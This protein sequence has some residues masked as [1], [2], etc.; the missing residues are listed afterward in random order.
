M[1]FWV[2]KHFVQLKSEPSRRGF[3]CCLA[4]GR[5]SIADLTP[6][7]QLLRSPVCHV[8]CPAGGT[9]QGGGQSLSL[10]SGAVTHQTAGSGRALELGGEELAR[11]I[12]PGLWGGRRRGGQEAKQGVQPH[13]PFL[14][15][16]HSLPALEAPGAAGHK[17]GPSGKAA[18][19]FLSVHLGA[20]PPSPP[21]SFLSQATST[22]GRSFQQFPAAGSRTALGSAQYQLVLTDFSP[23]G[24]LAA[25]VLPQGLTPVQSQ[26]R[27][28][29]P[30]LK[31]QR[32]PLS[33]GH[34]P[35]LCPGTGFNTAAPSS[36]PGQ[37][38][39]TR[40]HHGQHTTERRKCWGTQRRGS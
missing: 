3:A 28:Q 6:C 34:S 10:P 23:Q 16:R 40:R 30:G 38:R 13:A 18:A 11:R 4:H 5:Q 26:V 27:L 21:A 22:K 33:P 20:R 7:R 37:S 36:S 17:P 1:R 35:P 8:L 12:I 19:S 2:S 32:C 24:P 9:W 31:T 39:A 15:A 29:A 14:P 25:S